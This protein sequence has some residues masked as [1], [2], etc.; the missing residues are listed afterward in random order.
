VPER[1][2]DGTASMQ[3]L[4]TYLQGINPKDMLMGDYVKL[5][6][7]VSRLAEALDI[8]DEEGGTP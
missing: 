3:E 1:F 6:E 2:L 5:T 4:L 7:W 8:P